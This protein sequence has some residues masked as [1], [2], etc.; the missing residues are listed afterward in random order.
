MVQLVDRIIS[1]EV[2]DQT[3][4]NEIALGAAV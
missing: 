3:T 1:G 2:V 4:L